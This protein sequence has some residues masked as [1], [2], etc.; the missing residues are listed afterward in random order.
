MMDDFD[1]IH[2]S[3]H[4]LS[5]ELRDKNNVVIISADDAAMILSIMD[6]F[7]EINNELFSLKDSLTKTKKELESYRKAGGE[8]TFPG[9]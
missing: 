1:K 3:F 4:S 5:N 8:M 6:K 7:N 9:E 2:G